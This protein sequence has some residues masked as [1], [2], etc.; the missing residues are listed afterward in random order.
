MEIL[1]RTS[2]GLKRAYVVF[3]SQK[4]L[5]GAE[6]IQLQQ[7]AKRAKLHGFRPGKV[8]LNIIKKMYGASVVAESKKKAIDD[9]V[10]AIFK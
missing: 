4:E 9:T 10:I 6:Q 7:I 8:P 1:S 5:D 3:L 2:D